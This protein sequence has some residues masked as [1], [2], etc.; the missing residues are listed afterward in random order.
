MYICAKRVFITEL[1]VKM[2]S[3]TE[4]I[5]VDAKKFDAWF[6]SYKKW[7]LRS[8][9][10]NKFDWMYKE[11]YGIARNFFFRNISAE[12]PG[13]N[14][15][16]ASQR[17]QVDVLMRVGRKH[18]DKWEKS[19]GA[20]PG[21]PE[22]N[23]DE[24]ATLL[25]NDET[26]SDITV[27]ACV[28]VTVHPTLPVI[29]L[30]GICAQ[31]GHRSAQALLQYCSDYYPTI[32]KYYQLN[33]P[34]G[35]MAYI[36]GLS[37]DL[38]VARG[39]NYK[40]T[41]LLREFSSKEASINEIVSEKDWL[42]IQQTN[43]NNSARTSH[44]YGKPKAQILEKAQDQVAKM[45]GWQLAMLESGQEFVLENKDV[46]TDPEIIS[47][48]TRVVQ[49]AKWAPDIKTPILDSKGNHRFNKRTQKYMYTVEDG[50]LLQ[51][52]VV[53]R[54]LKFEGKRVPE[55]AAEQLFAMTH[56][57][58]FAAQQGAFCVLFDLRKVQADKNRAKIRKYQNMV[59]Q[60]WPFEGVK[61]YQLLNLPPMT[62]EGHDMLQEALQ[63]AQGQGQET[64]HARACT[65]LV[66]VCN[67][68]YKKKISAGVAMAASVKVGGSGYVFI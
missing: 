18:A 47:L 63:K 5:R 60:V 48:T 8:N 66:G 21:K 45:I 17:V 59:R 37:A 9:S 1:N 39:N 49:E 33:S 26:S 56:I 61:G 64:W 30:M 27:L 54:V 7:C 67:T 55:L 25:K 3:P 31:S 36:M 12:F 46:R 38:Y 65:A 41:K 15:P 11:K 43:S 57:D 32:G 2:D 29:Q 35:G 20:P 58:N 34:E 42:H 16:N 40:S 44:Y 4:I 22:T 13:D 68:I 52:K 62:E 10:E 19:F 14:S 24:I 51:E 28:T 53:E 23:F 6:E 50:D